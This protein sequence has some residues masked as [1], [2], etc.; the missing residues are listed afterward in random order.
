MRVLL[1]GD[2]PHNIRR[3]QACLP[4]GASVVAREEDLGA[5]LSR[6]REKHVDI[7]VLELPLANGEEGLH[8][9]ETLRAEQL[10]ASVVV[11]VPPEKQSL[12]ERALAAGADE[13][14]TLDELDGSLLSRV[15]RYAAAQ[16]SSR[17]ALQESRD[18]YD[19]LFF[20]NHSVMLLIDP[21]NGEIVDAN[22]AASRFYGY[23]RETLQ[24]MT[25]FEINILS[26][27]EIQAKMKRVH[28]EKCRHFYFRHRL[29]SGEI[30]DVEV[31]SGP[32]E[33][34]ERSL[35]YSLIHDITER[36]AAET[37][38]RWESATNAA[39]AQLARALIS[40]A[41]LEDIA[42]LVLEEARELTG[43]RFGYVGHINPQTGYLVSSTLTHD[44]WD[45]CQVEDKDFVFEEFGG[46]W[47][48]VLEHRQSMLVND[49]S[50]DP[51][52]TGIPAGHVPIKR[53][54]SAPALINEELLGQI[55]LANPDR[56]Y[57]QKDLDA[58]GR[59]ASLYALAVQR[60][61][62][63]KERQRYGEE[64]AT[65]Y[66]I[67]SALA[68][69]QE[70][71]ALLSEI[72]DVM[73]A[74]LKGDA[75]WVTALDVNAAAPNQTQL[76]TH[77]GIDPALIPDIQCTVAEMCPLP[78]YLPEACGPAHLVFDC[79]E[80]QP[81]LKEVFKQQLCIPLYAGGNVLGILSILWES[82]VDTPDFS[83]EFFTAVE[84]QIGVALQ[85]AQLYEAALQV[86]RLQVLNALDAALA[87]TLEP[88]RVAETT[89]RHLM[90]AVNASTGTLLLCEDHVTENC[91]YYALS[92]LT[93]DV[94]TQHRPPNIKSLK[95]LMQTLPPQSP[96]A[97]IGELQTRWL[98]VVNETFTEDWK[99]GTLLAP[100][101]DE[102]TPMGLLLLGPRQ[103]RREFSTEDRALIQAGASRAGQALQN[104][105]LYQASCAQSARLTTLNRISAVAV[106]S[107]DPDLVMREIIERTCEAL[108][109]L[110]G[111]ILLLNKETGQL[112]FAIT[113]DENAHPLQDMVLEPGR[114]IAGWVAQERESVVVNDVKADPRFYAG[115][116]QTVDFSTKSLLCAPLLHHDE[117]I[118]VME[119]VNKRKG[120]F[121]AQDL[122]LLESVASIAA[123]ALENARL[124]NNAQRRAEELAKINEVGLIL[125]SSLDSSRITEMALDQIS[126][127]FDTDGI[128]LL[129][130]DRRG[131][132]LH[133]VQALSKG[134]HKDMALTLPT[135]E[136]ISGW[137]FT[138]RK[139]VLVKD[140]RVDPRLWKGI[141][142]TMLE[143][144]AMLAAPLLSQTQVIG[145]I[146][147]MNDETNAYTEEDLHILQ[148]L[149]PTLSVALENARL[150]EDLKQLLREREEAQVRLI[151]TE[152][153][154]ALG[155][156]VASL[157]HEINNPLQAVQGCITLANEEIME[158][159]FDPDSL[160]Y[161]VNVAEDEIDRIAVILRRMRDF[162]RPAQQQYRYTDI[163]T[164]LESVLA[165]A[166]KQLQHN[167]VTVERQ[168][169]ETLPEI[170][171]NPDYLK[172]VF[173][174][175]VLN[176]MDA[177][178]E[179][180][181][182]TITTS[183]TTQY[184]EDEKAPGPTLSV[185]FTDTGEGMDEE[186]KSQ[187]FEPFFTTK[188]DGSGLG[189]SISYSII[190]AHQ[191]DI[192]I[193]SEVDVGTT[194]IIHLPFGV[195]KGD[196]SLGGGW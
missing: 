12:G 138:H 129:Q 112:R 98:G 174:N 194:M 29:A 41:S 22:P 5:G 6:L 62:A 130:A 191:G 74:V 133:V 8:A 30:R 170:Y 166:N 118:G 39:V 121:T 23:P 56:P 171:V 93:G 111:S 165:L 60:H 1:I 18:R 141:E 72:L 20:N 184:L 182:L 67:S 81:D 34:D 61:R 44:I 91:M 99:A 27:D 42:M 35:L 25:V 124:F 126:R 148:A 54:L 90:Q 7:M 177:M 155:R 195:E 43:S 140:A 186:T 150:Y 160:A 65:L 47:G 103:D 13:Y 26:R 85:N 89:L 38:L 104:A 101:W 97:L 17:R 154:A 144:R 88:E 70:S 119:I 95:A 134:K 175:F 114:G 181:T 24:Q 33:I 192:E 10:A 137:V 49:L 115:I 123:S 53:F 196:Y 159:Y 152:K 185:A 31:Y 135:D 125:T 69:L 193:I 79:Q 45:T 127:L 37:A 9:L 92:S 161:Y 108:D 116:D 153:M 143:P 132:S 157:A 156:L 100:V 86:D 117:V 163:H 73:L 50:A 64:Q 107:L 145:V 68:S 149:A 4:D 40:S 106:S 172:Q 78:D 139:P 179:G 190:K 164:I 136:S 105:H 32:I 180:G 58:I 21:S 162:Y 63:D 16:A 71:E 131:D 183:E 147:V 59:L 167:E 128:A 158:P 11:L 84:Q 176:A 110:E 113:L 169:D 188:P 51:R 168:W 122:Y 19:S 66:N 48:W 142:E 57:E 14:L 77:R 75:G 15:L 55:A 2:N 189:L 96:P 146:V 178:P 76:I 120:A 3:L 87:A 187:I 109:A 82:A 80:L 83:D 46:L 102:E 52:S 36:R 28:T 173:L 94:S 151:H